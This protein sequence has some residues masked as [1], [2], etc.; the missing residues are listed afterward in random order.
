MQS[1]RRSGVP[2]ALLLA[3]TLVTGACASNDLGPLD[4]QGQNDGLPGGT[5]PDGGN[6]GLPSGGLPGTGTTGTNAKP[7]VY[8][9][10]YELTSIVDLAGANAFGTT[11][12]TTLVQLSLFHDHPAATI[13]NLMALYNVPYFSEV[14]NVL[15]G[16]LKDKVTD[17][18]DQLIVQAVF[19]NVPV[20]DHAAELISDIGE[21]SRNVEM[22]TEMTLRA[23][24]PNAT[25]LRGDHVM[26][27]LGF[28]IWSLHAE[29]PLP[30]VFQQITQLEVRVGVT[31]VTGPLSGPQATITISKQ[32]FAI[33]YGDMIMDAIKHMIFE[34]VG[35]NDLGDYLNHLIPCGGIASSLGNICL[36][37]ECVKDL[38]SIDSM[39]G[40][41]TGGLSIVGLTVETE[42]RSLKVELADLTN[43]A[44]KMYDKG[45]ADK[46]G[47]GKMDAISDGSWDMLIHIG[48]VAKTIKAP[49]DGKRVA[50]Q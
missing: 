35:A 6:D 39:K 45:Y 28:H 25:L 32:N 7:T 43:G 19:D 18:L 26:K 5:T 40:F 12:S 27:S 47:D 17:L 50:D 36:L 29:I 3:L 48:G 15:P 31:P 46:V 38:V 34:P 41:C 42:V 10:R 21:A 2:T 37:G 16:F 49:F 24:T 33:P 44:A 4:G 30:T 1:I 11:I 20:V 22:V 13:L 14:W 8:T 23:N 9:G